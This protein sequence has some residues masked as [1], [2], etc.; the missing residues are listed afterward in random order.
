MR[1]TSTK[2]HLQS[3]V[4]AVVCAPTIGQAISLI[5]FPANNHDLLTGVHAAQSIQKTDWRS[6]VAAWRGVTGLPHYMC[7]SL[8]T[9]LQPFQA[10]PYTQD[11]ILPSAY[12]LLH[13]LLQ[14]S[15]SDTH[16]R[17]CPLGLLMFHHLQ[18][19][20]PPASPLLVPRHLITWITGHHHHH[21]PS[22]EEDVEGVDG[23]PPG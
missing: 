21:C 20:T 17:Q 9:P 1:V 6:L 3:H 4:A 22:R 15:C 2:L 8:P 23:D 18:A 7:R 5:P 10:L 11:C 19:N 13:T 16:L 14:L 12:C